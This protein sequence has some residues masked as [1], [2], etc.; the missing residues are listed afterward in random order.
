MNSLPHATA[1]ADTS[2]ISLVNWRPGIDPRLSLET[3]M[4]S[5]AWLLKVFPTLQLDPQFAW[6][7]L[8]D[9]TDTMVE[10]AVLTL[11]QTKRDV[12]PSSNWIA[13]IRM[14]ALEQRTSADDLTD[15]QQ[16]RLKELGL[17]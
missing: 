9:L 8:S 14:T 3:W 16:K 5:L 7:Q 13:E 1:S 4:R 12:Y 6:E 10:R 15:G 2:S 17:R 11:I